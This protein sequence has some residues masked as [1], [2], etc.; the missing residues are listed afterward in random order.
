MEFHHKSGRQDMSISGMSFSPAAA[1]QGGV[2][3]NVW[4]L[5]FPAWC[6]NQVRPP[7]ISLIQ[8]YLQQAKEM[9][10]WGL[11]AQHRKSS[12]ITLV[13]GRLFCEQPS[14]C[15]YPRISKHDAITTS[16]IVPNAYLSKMIK[17]VRFL[18]RE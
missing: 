7:Y 4:P 8:L 15:L 1:D 2:A 16:P 3:G 14:S 5:L 12:P 13:Y 17:S 6:R 10:I 9:E 18:C 11:K